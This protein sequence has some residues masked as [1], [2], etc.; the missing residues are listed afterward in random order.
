VDYDDFD[1]YNVTRYTMNGDGDDLFV[2][3]LT[4]YRYVNGTEDPF[5]YTLYADFSLQIDG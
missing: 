4:T 5:E 2:K 1:D 3:D